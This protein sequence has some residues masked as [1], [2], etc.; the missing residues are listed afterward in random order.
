MT[1]PNTC[2][3]FIECSSLRNVDPALIVSSA[4]R[5]MEW[6]DMVQKA[7]IKSWLNSHSQQQSAPIAAY[8]DK[9]MG[10]CLPLLL[11]AARD[12][13]GLT[14][15]TLLN[16]LLTLLSSFIHD[17]K[18]IKQLKAVLAVCVVWGFFGTVPA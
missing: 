1:V 7:V 12:F 4:I 2:R 3:V 16:S 10:E 9:L 15:I 11:A 13:T 14:E 5:T 17:I 8:L 6:S 18:D